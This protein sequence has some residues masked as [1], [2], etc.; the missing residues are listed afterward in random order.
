MAIVRVSTYEAVPG[1]IAWL[2][3]FVRRV[4]NVLTV[5]VEPLPTALAHNAFV[6]PSYRVVAGTAV[7]C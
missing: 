2:Q 6:I 5:Y 3:V 7:I 4:M 1:H